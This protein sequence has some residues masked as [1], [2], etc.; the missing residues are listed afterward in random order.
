MSSIRTRLCFS[1]CVFVMR[2][3]LQSLFTC[4]TV[5]VSLLYSRHKRHLGCFGYFTSCVDV[6]MKEFAQ[7]WYLHVII[8]WLICCVPLLF[9][10]VAS[11]TLNTRV[12]FLLDLLLPFLFIFCL[13]CPFCGCS[14]WQDNLEMSDFSPSL[15]PFIL[16]WF[17]RS[18]VF[19]SYHTTFT[20]CQSVNTPSL[21]HRAFAYPCLHL[22]SCFMWAFTCRRHRQH[23]ICDFSFPPFSFLGSSK[24]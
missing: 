13:F 24:F 20:L 6:W 14:D 23:V 12:Q 1:M 22:Q 18:L 5:W 15:N 3:K 8:S 7:I 2:R 17:S 16:D 4:S 9:G 19:F 10:P 21:S 11:Y